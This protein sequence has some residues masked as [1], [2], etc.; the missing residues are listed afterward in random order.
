MG[1]QKTTDLGISDAKILRLQELTD[2]R[3]T[4]LELFRADWDIAPTPLQWNMVVSQ[5]N[6]LRGVH[7]HLDHADYLFVAAGCMYLGLHDVR[8][9]SPTYGVARLISITGDE[10]SVALVPPGVLHGFCFLEPTTYVYGLTACWTPA[11]DK[12]C[13]W[14]DKALN[15]DWPVADPLLSARDRAAPSLENLKA[16]LAPL[17]KAP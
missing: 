10:R 15:I 13:N 2:E 14:S 17:W 8:P 3:G 7:V 5:P 11:D 12:G 1:I 9:W 6:S 16:D 4:L